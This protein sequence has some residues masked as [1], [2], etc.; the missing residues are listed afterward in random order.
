MKA[1]HLYRQI[2][3]AALLLIGIIPT[4]A[5][6]PSV[7]KSDT[8]GQMADYD[9]SKKFHLY[10]KHRDPKISV[11]TLNAAD[12]QAAIFHSKITFTDPITIGLT[13]A[14]LQGVIKQLE[15]S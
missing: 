15:A 11:N 9:I 5:Q 4:H 13:F 10:Y 14:A 8:T 12:L 1:K 7:Q 2:F 3:A 6:L